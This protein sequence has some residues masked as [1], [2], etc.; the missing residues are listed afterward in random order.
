MHGGE[1]WFQGWLE[2]YKNSRVFHH[3]FLL[4]LSLYV[5]SFTVNFIHV[6]VGG[7]AAAA[8]KAYTCTFIV[9][10][11][12]GN[13]TFLNQRNGSLN[14]NFRGG[15]LQQLLWTNGKPHSTRVVQD[16]T[17]MFSLHCL[18]LLKPISWIIPTYIQ[19][20]QLPSSS[21]SRRS[22]ANNSN[23]VH[24]GTQQ[25]LDSEAIFSLVLAIN[26]LPCNISG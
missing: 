18:F 11:S 24:T 20:Q 1:K 8:V 17:A 13:I 23:W 9:S 7:S 10:C 21:S 22:L 26:F 14:P 3:P 2:I 12:F 4:H 15:W 19:S 5:V 16:Q 25:N 6:A